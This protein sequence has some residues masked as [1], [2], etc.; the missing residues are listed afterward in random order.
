MMVNDLL[1]GGTTHRDRTDFVKKVKKKIALI[2]YIRQ[3]RRV[4]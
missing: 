1:W 3:D 2:F 4:R